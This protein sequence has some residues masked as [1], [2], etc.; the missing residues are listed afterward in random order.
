MLDKV[1]LLI[2]GLSNTYSICQKSLNVR[3]LRIQ[4]GKVNVRDVRSIQKVFSLS[5][6]VLIRFTQVK[7]HDYEVLMNFFAPGVYGCS[8]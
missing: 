7:M 2:S 5:T 1:T 3:T 4:T 6:L 8:I